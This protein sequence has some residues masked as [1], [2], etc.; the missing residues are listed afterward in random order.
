MTIRNAKQ[1]MVGLPVGSWSD[2][3]DPDRIVMDVVRDCQMFLENDTLQLGSRFE[4]R[5]R[6]VEGLQNN[7]PSLS[8][9]SKR[10][11]QISEGS[12]ID[13]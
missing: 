1:R 10:L 6:V 8:R 4:K 3:I 2:A 13:L 11:K 12:Q 9:S 5:K 7:G